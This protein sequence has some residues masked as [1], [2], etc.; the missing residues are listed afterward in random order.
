M[1]EETDYFKESLGSR[2]RSQSSDQLVCRF[3]VQ[4]KCLKGDTCSYSH[5]L[6]RTVEDDAALLLQESNSPTHSSSSRISSSVSNTLS[7]GGTCSICLQAVLAEGRRFGL[8]PLC[9]H[10]FCLDCIL[11][12]RQRSSCASRESARRCP[13]CRIPSYFVIPSNRFFTGEPKRKRVHEYLTFLS[14]K[15]CMYYS[16]TAETELCPYGSYCFFQ[17][18]HP[19]ANFSLNEE[20]IMEKKI[21]LVF[22]ASA[23]PSF[24]S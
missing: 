23:P 7:W 12:W 10:M 24:I 4:N 9:N 8:L 19:P 2:S 1:G 13:V 22:T 14:Q 16:A 15:P 5:D 6:M 18:R 17:H 11:A 20:E 3:Y 21:V